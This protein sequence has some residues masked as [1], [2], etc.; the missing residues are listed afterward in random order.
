MTGCG[1]KITIRKR[2]INTQ[3]KRERKKRNDIINQLKGINDKGIKEAKWEMREM[4]NG[5]QH[6]KQ[7]NKQNYKWQRMVIKRK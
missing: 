1:W 4:G 3:N 6:E 5:R 7:T 2:K